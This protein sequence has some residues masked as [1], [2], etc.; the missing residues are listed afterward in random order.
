MRITVLDNIKCVV[1]RQDYLRIAP[2]LSHTAE[3]WTE[4]PFKKE[5]VEYQKKWIRKSKGLYYFY[6]GFLPRVLAMFPKTEV[7]AD[8]EPILDMQNPVLQ[9]ITFRKDQNRQLA[10][11]L[12]HRRGIILAATGTGKT[13]LQAGLMSAFKNKKVLLLCHKSD[14]ISQTVKELKNEFGFKEVTQIGAGAPKFRSNCFKGIICSTVQSF[15]K[16]PSM[17]YKDAFDC[18]IIDEAHMVS[19]EDGMYGNILQQLNAPYRY[20]FTATLPDDVE[21]Q[22]AMEAFT[23]P[24]IDELSIQEAGELEIL[25]KPKIKIIKAPMN[26]AVKG[27]KNYQ[28]AVDKGITNSVPR[29]RLIIKTAKEFTKQGK[30]VLIMVV[31]TEH[32]RMLQR[33]GDKEGLYLRFIYGGTKQKRRDTIKDAL[34]RKRIKAAICSVVWKEGINI[35]SLDVIILAGGGKSQ[36]T[37]LQNIGRG[38]RRTK[39]KKDVTI[40]DIFDPSHYHFVNHFGERVSLYCENGWM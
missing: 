26:Y 25:A 35:P 30:T 18:V 28:E 39:E 13:I 22:F 32:G 27:I 40:V 14:I 16:L 9:G 31:R 24:V 33:I 7:I 21:A 19:K 34:I 36:I 23:G 29:N 3:Y 6:A 1:N 2:V 8:K 38:L 17:L 5:R 15:H 20:C 4:G 12:K 11:A 10:A 37:V